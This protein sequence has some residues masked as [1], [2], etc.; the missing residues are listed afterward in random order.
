[1]PQEEN[2]FDAHV[3]IFYK[4]ELG[5]KDPKAEKLQRDIEAVFPD[6][7]V[8]VIRT[9]R[10]VEAEA[11]AEDE[12]AARDEIQGATDKLLAN[13]LTEEG[14]VTVEPKTKPCKSSPPQSSD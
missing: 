12:Q 6:S 7:D 10:L 8:R 1:M 11:C 2:I 5:I 4:P 14:T 3:E 13:A 9:G